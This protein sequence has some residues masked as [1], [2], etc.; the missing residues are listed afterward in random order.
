MK[1]LTDICVLYG[2]RSIQHRYR[3]LYLR[4]TLECDWMGNDVPAPTA[5]EVIC[6]I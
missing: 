3:D 4:F 2:I 6:L 1:G 5:C